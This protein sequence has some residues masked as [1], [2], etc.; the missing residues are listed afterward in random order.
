MGHLSNWSSDS[1]AHTRICVLES[2]NEVKDVRMATLESENTIL[3]QENARL[4]DLV[5]KLLENKK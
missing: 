5:T 2:Q 3:K 4:R 1:Q